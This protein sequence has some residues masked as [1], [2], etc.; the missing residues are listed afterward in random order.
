MAEVRAMLSSSRLTTL[1]G[2]GGVGKSR[3]ALRVARGAQRGF[4][5]GAWLVEL[6]RLQ[7]P[8]VLGAAVAASL[9]LRELSTRDAETVL[10]DYL[11]D[12]QL[13]LLLDNCEHVVDECARLVTALLAV[14]PGLRILATSREPLGAAGEHVWQVPPL[15]VLDAE[16]AHERS[17]PGDVR[18]EALS[19]FEL[20]TAAVLPGFAVDSDNLATAARLCQ[21]LEGLP[22]AIELAAVRMRALSMEQILSRLD[23]RF[24]LLTGGSRIDPPHHRTLRATFDWSFD[25]C[26][27]QEQALW[28]RMS[29]FA[30]G[31][32]LEAAEAVCADEH[33]PPHEI[34]GCV[35]GLVDQSLLAREETGSA[36]RYR[37]LETV[38]Q[39]GHQRLRE[40]DGEAALRLRHRDYYLRLAERVEA[41]WF[42]PR[43]L[44]W[45]E[46]LHAEHPNIQAALE[47]CL[48]EPGGARTAQRLAG[49][50]WFYWIAHGLLTEGRHWLDKALALDAEPG[51]ER[52]K[53]LWVNGYI[54][55]RQGDNNAA[56]AMLEECQDLAQLLG[57]DAALVRG[58]QMTGLAELMHGDHA[59][60]VKLLEEALVHHRAAGEPNANLALTMFY[61]AL[62]VCTRGDLDRA[63]ALCQECRQMCESCGERWSLSRTLWI[64]GL[65]QWARGEP[66]PADDNVRE[67]LKIERV[68]HDPISVALCVEV[69]GWIA[70]AGG[71]PR[72]AATLFG[73]SRRLFEPLSEFLFGFA[74]YLDWHDQAE[75]RA[76]QALGDAGFDDAF[77]YGRGLDLPAATAYALEEKPK[78]GRGG[79]AGSSS[80]LTRREREIAELVTQGLSNKEIASRLVI[81]KRTVDAHVE[82]IFTKL[83]LN[84]RNQVAAWMAKQSAHQQNARDG[85]S[86]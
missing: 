82:H 59:R 63:V 15:S 56:L 35:A 3:L 62:A 55:T 24:R 19:L 11:A 46:I 32:S 44:E 83:G 23:D 49:A 43:Q 42:G 17:A 69:L 9:G 30:G 37:L 13:L 77:R 25:L 86:G 66:R 84:S 85:R 41:D 39:Y 65:A 47:F 81:A 51:P 40:S 58:L 26:S 34:L 71:K 72:R 20:R 75:A 70:A 36:V 79:G 10:A 57:D 61:L 1:T 80:P 4:R 74:Y 38:R 6:A 2:V 28:R 50:L 22:L 73:V 16:D 64:L 54:A 33:L 12:K 68:L 53:A 8:S 67:S 18:Y 31:F 27:R 21:R 45:L 7:A 29:V 76:R 14:S 78:A 52:V 48:A 60:G 5:D